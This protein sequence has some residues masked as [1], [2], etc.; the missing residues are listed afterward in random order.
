M[1]KAAIVL[2]VLVLLS[3]AC[4]TGNA[5]PVSLKEVTTAF[6]EEKITL[7]KKKVKGNHIFG[8]KLN[9]VKPI[10]YQVEGNSF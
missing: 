9:R 3:S 7:Q 1:T 2:S 10:S 5:N 6:E 4:Q 8:M